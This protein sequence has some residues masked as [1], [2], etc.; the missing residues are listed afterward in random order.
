MPA[1]QQWWSP[2]HVS[3]G[4]RH[5]LALV[6]VPVVVAAA[7]VGLFVAAGRSPHVRYRPEEIDVDL[8]AVKGMPAVVEEA[9]RT[10]DPFPPH[11]WPRPETGAASG[12]GV[13]F[14]GPAG[15]GKLHLGR[16][17]AREAGVPFLFVSSSAFHS[18]IH[19]R[20]NRRIRAYF[21]ALR[22]AVRAEGGAIGFIDEIDAIDAPLSGALVE[23]L[24]GWTGGHPL[25]PLAV[26]TGPVLVIGATDRVADV[27][28]ALLGPGGFDH[29]ISFDLPGR[30]GRRDIIAHELSRRAHEADLG[31]RTDQLAASTFGYSPAMLVHLLDEALVQTLRRGAGALSWEDVVRAKKTGAIGTSH[32]AA[33]TEAAR[34]TMATH[35][36]GHATVAWFVGDFRGVDGLSII[37]RTRAHGRV[38]LSDSEARSGR[39]AAEQRAHVQVAL[40]GMAAEQRLFGERTRD[41]AGDL[42]YATTVAARIVAHDGP[43]GERRAA[44]AELLRG[45]RVEVNALISSHR[46]VV[47]ALRDALLEED[48]LVGQRIRE[49]IL[50]ALSPPRSGRDVATHA[51]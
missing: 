27:D 29:T 46:P 21:A 6:G 35:E 19:G 22:A 8:D 15:T 3:K 28:P 24:N 20:T 42:R 23:A 47:E 7:T 38:S 9:V 26:P 45:A 25:G 17:L 16:A 32:L 4:A 11:A 40:G 49:V 18:T 41:S 43:A 2:P 51:G 50:T 30:A 36:A 12:R 31:A 34:R 44:T 48:E 39:T 5:A 10:L 37:E 33:A 14:E 1:I 13:L